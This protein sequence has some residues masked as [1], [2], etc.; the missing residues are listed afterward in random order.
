MWKIDISSRSLRSHR[1]DSSSKILVSHRA[2]GNKRARHVLFK[3]MIIYILISKICRLWGQWE[4]F[5]I[6]GNCVYNWK[7][8]I[9]STLHVVDRIQRH[10]FYRNPRDS[11]LFVIFDLC[12]NVG[13]EYRNCRNDIDL[14]DVDVGDVLGN[15]GMCLENHSRT[16]GTCLSANAPSQSLRTNL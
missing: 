11:I 9:I 2:T 3:G 7:L 8:K 16:T 6:Q 14:L 12:K 5:V 13:R 1:P 4:Y 15:Q 10:K